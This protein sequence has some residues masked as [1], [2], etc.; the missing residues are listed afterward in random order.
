MIHYALR[1]GGG[2]A[3]DGWFNGSAGFEAQAAQGL[4]TCPVCGGADVQRALMS[5]SLNKGGL[6]RGGDIA[7]TAEAAAPAPVVT[8]VASRATTLP[9]PDHVRAMLQR[10]RTEVEKSCDYVGPEFANVARRIHVGEEPP[11]PIYGEATQEEAAALEEDG[12]ETA[13]V[14]WVPRADS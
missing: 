9:L 7:A 12:I 8:D 14:P 4:L 1:C 5:P 10:I 3:F 2:H 13:R 6:R 11:R